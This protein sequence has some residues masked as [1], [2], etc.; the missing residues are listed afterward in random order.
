M[1]DRQLEDEAIGRRLPIAAAAAS[2][3]LALRLGRE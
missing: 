2:E 1:S 3:S